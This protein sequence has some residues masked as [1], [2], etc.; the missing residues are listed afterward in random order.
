MLISHAVKIAMELL[1]ARTIANKVKISIVPDER[2]EPIQGENLKFRIK[3]TLTQNIP[4][5]SLVGS[6]IDV[7]K[8]RNLEVLLDLA[9]AA[10]ARWRSSV[11]TESP[12]EFGGN[13]G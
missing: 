11:S 1:I 9:E 10:F 6:A 2:P 3:D 4:F 5:N 12:V 13:W 7:L 8:R